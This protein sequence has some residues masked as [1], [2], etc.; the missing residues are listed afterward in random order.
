MSLLSKKIII[1]WKHL[2][3]LFKKLVC[4]K[5]LSLLQERK[6]RLKKEGKFLT[7]AQKEQQAR[8]QA[9]LDSM[10]KQGIFNK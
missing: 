1:S 7:K 4:I 6:A 8:A 5:R 3:K 9:V 2:F 10:K